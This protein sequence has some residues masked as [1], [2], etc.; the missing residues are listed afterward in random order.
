MTTPNV[1]G[2][3]EGQTTGH[4]SATYLVEE[5]MRTREALKALADG[6]RLMLESH[7]RE[8]VG[9]YCRACGVDLTRNALHRAAELL[10]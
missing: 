9:W 3:H 2:L 4:Y 7:D 10:K 6:A 1:L 8:C 5:L